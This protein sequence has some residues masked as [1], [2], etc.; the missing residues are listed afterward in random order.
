[1]RGVADVKFV[2]APDDF[3]EA[4]LEAVE[5]VIDGVSL[6]DIIKHADGEVAFA[7]L[8]PPAGYIDA[9]RRPVKGRS[10]ERVEVLGCGC[11]YAGCSN[12]SAVC[13]VVRG[14][15]VWSD[16][17]A[18][19]RPFGDPGARGYEGLGPYE[20]SVENYVTALSAPARTAA[21]VREALDVGRLAAGYPRDPAGWLREMTMAFG[22]DFLAPYEPEQTRDVLVSGLR[23]LAAAG[24]PITE[25]DVRAWM[26][27][28]RFSDDAINRYVEWFRVLPQ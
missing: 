24:S 16:F 13:Q 25:D 7:G 12:V 18:T 21:P 26:R 4:E 28:R 9:W 14:A 8:T 23:A 17:R 22:R 2:I 10:V 1:M 20:F 15:V 27:E 3:G 11:G 19:I 5:P 6:V